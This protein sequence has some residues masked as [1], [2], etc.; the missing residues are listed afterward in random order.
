M[1]TKWALW[2]GAAVSAGV[3]LP[4]A[5]HA[6]A[7]PFADVPQTHWAYDAVQQLA[8]R[9]IFTG[10]PDGTFAGKRAL[11]RYEFAV[12]LQRMLQEV[13]RNIAAIELK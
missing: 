8:Q 6:Q 9:G 11:T 4:V 12:A 3:L 5:A 2:A 7:G 13:Q 1:K 10:Y